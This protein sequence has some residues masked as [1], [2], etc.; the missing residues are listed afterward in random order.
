MPAIWPGPGTYS[1]NQQQQGQMEKT[2]V[3]HPG[4]E[5]TLLYNEFWEKRCKLFLKELTL[6]I[7]KG[8][9]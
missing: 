1:L 9:G 3:C 7:D 2:H 4:A 6:T 5:G 8:M